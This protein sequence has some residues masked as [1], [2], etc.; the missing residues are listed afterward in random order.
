MRNTSSVGGSESKA[1]RKAGKPEER[2]AS[3]S[4]I[5]A[6]GASDERRAD[7]ARRWLEVQLKAAGLSQ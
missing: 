7:M 6:Y 5:R 3:S 4:R 1:A 2:T